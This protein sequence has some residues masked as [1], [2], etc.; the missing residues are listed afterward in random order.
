MSD[1]AVLLDQ[2]RIE[3]P[4]EVEVGRTRGWLWIV[5]ALAAAALAA[6][7]WWYLTQRGVAV[8]AAAVQA[9]PADVPI[10]PGSILD[11]SGYVVARRQATVSSK[12]M[13]KVVEVAIEE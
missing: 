9:A 5:A 3:R 13:G 7:T 2:L 12:V 10:G 1:R 11:A 8:S 4:A 6:S